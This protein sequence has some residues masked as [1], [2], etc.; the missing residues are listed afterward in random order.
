MWGGRDDFM[1]SFYIDIDNIA[2]FNLTGFYWSP[3]THKV[4][5]LTL[6]AL[7]TTLTLLL[8]LTLW[9]GTILGAL[10]TMISSIVCLCSLIG[11]IGTEHRFVRAVFKIP[12]VG[13]LCKIR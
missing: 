12:G 7:S 3:E 11:R 10:I 9:I 8:S 2:Y 1:N 6:A 4:L 5:W 13:S